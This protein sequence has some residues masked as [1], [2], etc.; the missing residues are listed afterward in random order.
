MSDSVAR[1]RRRGLIG[2]AIAALISVAL[3][4]LL[5]SRL[6]AAN[7]AA[8]VNVSHGFTLDGKPAP[9]FTVSVVNSPTHQAQTIHLAALKG[10]PVV[11]NFFA[12]WCV[13]C[14]DEAPILEA[15][16]Q[17]Y[18]PKGVIFVGMI[19]EDSASNAQ[20]FY[21]QYGLSFPMGPDPSGATAISYGVT[22]V[23]ETVFI[24]AQG[25]VV[26]KY[27]G[28]EDDGTLDRSIQGLLK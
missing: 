19:Y 4:A 5:A 21:Q 12:S 7:Q 8:S 3:I 22:G 17:K 23:P 15:A 10:H 26:S 16:W 14:A 27:G 13:P 20:G 9:D 6:L 2:L 24:S 25:I 11:V 1:A 28:P 18:Q